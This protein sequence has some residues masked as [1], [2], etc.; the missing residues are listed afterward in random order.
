MTPYGVF[1]PGF[2]AV[3][4]CKSP[5]HVTSFHEGLECCRATFLLFL[6][7]SYSLC[8]FFSYVLFSALTCHSP[9]VKVGPWPAVRS[10]ISVSY[11]V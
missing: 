11:R 10:V 9:G 1:P 6:I 5:V 8:P 7:F 3:P 4:D 2:Q